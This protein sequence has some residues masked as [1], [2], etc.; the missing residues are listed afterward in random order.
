M[1]VKTKELLNALDNCFPIIN[2]NNELQELNSFIFYRNFIISYNEKVCILFPFNFDIQG[3]VRAKEF[4]K[5]LSKIEQEDLDI[6]EEQSKYILKTKNIKIEFDKLSISI[7]N[8]LDSLIDMNKNWNSLDKEFKKGINN[9]LLSNFIDILEGVFIEKNIFYSTN[10][11]IIKRYEVE[12]SIFE[13]SVWLNQSFCNLIKDFDFN[14]YFLQNEWMFCKDDSGFIVCSKL[15]DKS[16]YPIEVLKKIILN[17]D[18]EKLIWFNL[19]DGLIK[20]LDRVSVF[21][22]KDNNNM[23]VILNFNK[24]GI[25]VKG[26]QSF[27]NYYEEIVWDSKID[28]DINV[29]V[30]PMIFKNHLKNKFLFSLSSF[31]EN[32]NLDTSICFL[33]NKDERFLVLLSIINN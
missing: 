32:K 25:I 1:K 3:A 20:A 26:E 22:E 5:I 28:K 4:Y 7:S 23:N 24:N 30:E 17:Y 10:R 16:K 6:I 33:W 9:V 12:Q 19:P 2:H 13:D 27:A 18:L 14:S 8:F 15:L 11:K 29:L 21:Y 31:S